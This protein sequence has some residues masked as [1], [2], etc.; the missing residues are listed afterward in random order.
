[1]QALRRSECGKT[2]EGSGKKGGE[3]AVGESKKAVD[4]STLKSGLTH[5]PSLSSLF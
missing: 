4:L 3:F 2:E 1:V 5:Y